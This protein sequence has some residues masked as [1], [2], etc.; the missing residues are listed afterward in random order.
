METVVAKF[1]KPL[2]AYRTMAGAGLAT[3]DQ[4]VDSTQVETIERPK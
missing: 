1:E 2:L 4:P 3:S